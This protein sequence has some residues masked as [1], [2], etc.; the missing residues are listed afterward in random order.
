MFYCYGCGTGGDVF[1]FLMKLEQAGFAEIFRRLAERAGVALEFGSS[2]E[3]RRQAD[4]GNLFQANEAALGFYHYLLMRH[5]TGE[6]GRQYFMHRGLSTADMERFG[7]GWAP[8]KSVIYPYLIKHGFTEETLLSAGL[9]GRREDGRCYDRFRQRVMFSIYDRQGRV[10]GFGGRTLAEERGPKYLNSPETPI[11]HKGKVLYGLNWAQTEARRRGEIVLV[12]GYMDVIS[13]HRHGLCHVVAPLGTALGADQAK[14]LHS[15]TPRVIVSF[16]ADTAGDKATLRGLNVLREAGCQVRV[17]RLPEGYDPD[18]L[19]CELGAESLERAWGEEAV[20]LIVHKLEQARRNRRL[21]FLEDKLV[22]VREALPDIA[23]LE[24]PLEVQENIRLVAEQLAVQE[25]ALWQELRK[26]S[27]K[28]IRFKSRDNKIATLVPAKPW[29]MTAEEELLALMLQDKVL[30]QR[31]TA[32]LGWDFFISERA[33]IISKALRQWM[34][35]NTEKFDVI[36]L[37]DELED[38]EAAALAYD[39]IMR[40]RAVFASIDDNIRSIQAYSLQEEALEL[41]NQLKSSSEEE[42]VKLLS[43]LAQIQKNLRKVQEQRH[44]PGERGET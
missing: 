35:E 14:L 21:T 39:L 19:V 22:V 31:I 38:R 10:I 3:N 25:E 34:E 26:L 24:S 32:V 42:S 43:R 40:D 13:A 27:N 36:D 20:S 17:A 6:P 18:K 33:G 1:S 8:D 7:L 4:Y 30:C 9:I 11:F 28:D 37:I 5:R 29:R 15:T 12:E 2:M 16:D 44:P 41:Q 23:R